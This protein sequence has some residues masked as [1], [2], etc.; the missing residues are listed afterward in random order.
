MFC[1]HWYRA[2]QWR[3]RKVVKTTDA[4]AFA[5]RPSAG[6]FANFTGLIQFSG[7]GALAPD[8]FQ[9]S[10]NQLVEL[11]EESEANA[12]ITAQILVGLLRKLLADPPFS[13]SCR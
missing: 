12:A 7:L 8:L 4:L 2:R 6:G 3:V 5:T 10:R 11:M 13:A 9:R 1:F